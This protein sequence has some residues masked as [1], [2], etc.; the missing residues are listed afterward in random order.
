MYAIRS[1]YD[2]STTTSP[3]DDDTDDDGILDGSE[4]LGEAGPIERGSHHVR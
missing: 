3:V 1:Y 4:D 2:P